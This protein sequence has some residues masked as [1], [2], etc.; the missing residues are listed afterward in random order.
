MI[1][2]WVREVSYQHK[3]MFLHSSQ[4]LILQVSKTIRDILF[5]FESACFIPTHTHSFYF[6]VLN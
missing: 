6:I 4:S 1:C 3:A 5:L 2:G